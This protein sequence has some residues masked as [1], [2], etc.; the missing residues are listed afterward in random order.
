MSS[1]TLRALFFA[2]LAFCFVLVLVLTVG[3]ASAQTP[4]QALQELVEEEWDGPS[5]VQLWTTPSADSAF[6]FGQNQPQYFRAHLSGTDSTDAA[7][8]IRCPETANNG[9]PYPLTAIRDSAETVVRQRRGLGING[10]LLPLAEC[11]TTIAAI[12]DSIRSE[13]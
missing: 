7:T 3:C 9:D 4:P 5:E 13:E 6:V 8:W 2:W 11:A 1:K 10:I 12:E